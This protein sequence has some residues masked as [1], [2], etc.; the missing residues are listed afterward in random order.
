MK[1]QGHP[2]YHK[3]AVIKCACGNEIVV[4]STM[5]T[6]NVELCH[7]CHPFYTGKQKLVDTARRVEKFQEKMA[8]QKN[9]ATERKGKK[10]KKDAQKKAR[11]QK[12]K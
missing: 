5:E 3:Q 2:T 4:G 6:I 9:T 7:I 12:S 8:K 10:A 11:A 1:K